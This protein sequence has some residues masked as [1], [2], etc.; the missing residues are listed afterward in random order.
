MKMLDAMIE[1]EPLPPWPANP[2]VFV[3]GLDQ[4]N[5]WQA[6]RNTR[7]AHFRGSERLDAS[8]M[9]VVIRS[10]TVCNVVQRHIPF[11]L[12]LLSPAEQQLIKEEGPYTE[13]YRN[14]LYPLE[15][16]CVK[17]QLRQGMAELMQIISPCTSNVNPPTVREVT[18]AALAR[19]I[20]NLGGPS[21]IS[22][23][24]SIPVCDTKSFPDVFK[25]VPF[26]L[27]R[28]AMTMLV[29]VV[30]VDGQGVE[31]LRAAKRR[32]PD[33]YRCIL[34]GQGW[35]HAF[36]HFMFPINAG[37][38]ECCLCTFAAW[39]QKRKQI[40]KEMNDLEND[41][42]K[43]IL[44]FHRCVTSAILCCFVLH[45]QNPPPSLFISD[46]ELYASL[47]QHEGAITIFNYLHNG[48]S[49]ILR[50]Q[51]AIRTGNGKLFKH[52][53]AYA[54]HV[55]RSLS[56]KPKAV[57]INFTCLLGLCCAHPKLQ[58][59]LENVGCL[60]LFGDFLMAYDRFLEYVNWC[61]QRRNS[62]FRGY[63]SQLHFTKYLKPLI[64]VDA[65]WKEVDG[66]GHG[67]DDGIPDFLYN[68]VNV[69]YQKLCENLPQDVTIPHVGN[70][71]WFTGNAVPLNGG[72]FRERMP[73]KYVW[74]VAYGRCKGVGRRAMHW[75]KCA[76]TFITYHAFRE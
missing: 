63:D 17:A 62:A 48:G 40:Y 60:S 2:H 20:Q 54:I 30:N 66:G 59:V 39:L 67:F 33:E 71:F 25:F 31:I 38:W 74:E 50:Y 15:P 49:P 53:A 24:P 68:D 23:L 55:Q 58:T 76:M 18:A 36:C 41:N 22:I 52:L 47:I 13:D 37:Y 21:N 4:C 6:A 42:A 19:P 29:M 32:W 16:A 57:F 26:M 10:E 5:H 46:P 11:T 44:D 73:W 1:C 51:R 8:G 27:L 72:D 61:Q 12:G 14:I 69:L 65:A 7:K 64:H 34:I 45:V 56:F 3:F 9:P 43:H 28:C 75:K 35:F 70:T